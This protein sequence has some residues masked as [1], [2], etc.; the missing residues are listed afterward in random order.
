MILGL[1]LGL[2]L[3]NDVFLG[4]FVFLVVLPYVMLASRWNHALWRSR[5]REVPDRGTAL[6]N[7]AFWTVVVM[8]AVAGIAGSQG[9]DVLPWVAF[10]VQAAITAVIVP[11]TLKRY[12][13]VLVRR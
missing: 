11:V 12:P 13:G 4:P 1:V 9:D 7:T 3:A 8:M 10:A 6:E 2:L 5:W